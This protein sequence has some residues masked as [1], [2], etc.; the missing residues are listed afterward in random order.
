MKERYIERVL[1]ALPRARRAGVRRDLEEIFADSLARGESEAQVLERLGRNALMVGDRCFD[2]RG[3]RA[4]GIDA[5]GILHGF[6]SEAELR[7]SG[8]TFL[9]RGAADL[10]ALIY[11]AE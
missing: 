2:I 1:R 11:D 3:A 4:N 5:A 8:A 9:V 6:G 10:R 7:E